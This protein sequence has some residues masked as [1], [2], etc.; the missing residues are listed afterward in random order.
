MI[1]T[2]GRRGAVALLG[3]S[4]LTLSLSPVVAQDKT[5]ITFSA[6]HFAEAGRGDA[7]REWVA[8]FNNSQ[9]A[10]EV[11]T[12]TIPFSSY[13]TTI[14]TQMGGGA[15]PDLIR[16][17]LPEFY[18][19]A[20]A[21][22]FASLEAV[23]DDASYSFTSADSYMKVNGTRYG[24]AFDTANYALIYNADLL[25]GG[26]PPKTFDEF[27]AAAGAATK[28]GNYGFAFRATMAERGGVWY[29]VTNFVY[30][31][32]GR[33]SL[34]DG[35]PTFNSPEVVAGIEAYKKVYD[36][37]V[38]PRGTDAATYR[39]MFWE[40]HVAME[41][42]N[43][44]VA[45]ILTSQGAGKP[46]GA[47]PSPFPHPEQGM[48][49]APVG[50]NANSKSPEAA[51][52]FLKW[53]L[54]PAQQQELQ[55]LLGAANVATIVPRT[56]AELAERPWLVAYDAQTV[57]SVPAIAQGLEEKSPEIQQIVVEQLLR[58][59][60]GGVSPQDAMDQAQKLVETRVLRR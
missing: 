1:T 35:T 6:S 47:A 55:A 48:I 18:A 21:G 15:G 56:D 41:I 52:T 37:G 49:L 33:W 26:A 34:P 51:A 28:D 17:D 38:I 40:G 7:L 58:V 45:T 43:G 12:V 57:N 54:E 19:A 39:R 42:D 8:K 50:I 4:A 16:F 2:I 30:G 44:G 24:V 59:L 20:N 31:F 13:A 36:A 9:A 27:L 14:F 3:A 60:Q 11:Q 25:P 10:I 46:I 29:D 22:R 5:V 32:G 23:I 53:A